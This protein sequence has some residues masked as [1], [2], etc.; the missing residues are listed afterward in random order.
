MPNKWMRLRSEELEG[1]LAKHHEQGGLIPVRENG[2]EKLFA[3]DR[4]HSAQ[5]MPAATR[6]PGSALRN[7]A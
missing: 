3:K 4:G 1:H 5:K 6:R 2:R 7:P